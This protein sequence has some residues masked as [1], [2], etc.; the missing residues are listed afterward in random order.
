M[1]RLFLATFAAACCVLGAGVGAAA[2]VQPNDPAWPDQWAQRQIGLPQVWETTTGDPSVVIATI[3]TGVNA[4]PDLADALVPGWD[5]VDNDAVAQDTHSHG[6]R[7]ASVIAARGNNQIAMAG[8]CWRCKIMPIRVTAGGSVRPDRIATGIYYAVDHGARIINV[9]LTHAGVDSAEREAVRYAID[10][11]VLVVAGAGNVGTDVPQYPA[12]YP[13]VLSVGATDD[14]DTLYFW[15]SRGPWVL[16]TAPGCHMIVDADTPPGTICGTSFTPAAVSGVAGLLI[17][18]NPSLTVNQVIGVLTA[19]AR[20]VPGVLFGRVD[21]AAAFARLGLLAPSTPTAPQP[22]PTP[23]PAT[24]RTIVVRGQRFNREARLE[25]GTFRKGFR[26]SF[27]VGKGKFELQ[28]V[29]PLAG[30]CTLSLISASDLTIAAPAVRNLLS[31]SLQV[32]A[33]RYTAAI[34]CRGDRSRRFSLGVIAMFPQAGP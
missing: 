28:L 2:P 34:R 13:G 33:G 10:R 32:P 20:P 12:A 1:K 22:T 4:I 6:T 5:F 17:S 14:T 25:T 24:T 19:T 7:V 30:D 11:G 26:T 15:S 23:T 21:A 9:S 27:K 8:H 3:D 16:L 18:R 31:I 29:T